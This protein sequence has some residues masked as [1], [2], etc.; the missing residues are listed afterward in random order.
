[1]DC[2]AVGHDAARV[3]P[4]CDV[5]TS[6]V[7]ERRA[8]SSRRHLVARP[9]LF[10]RAR[11]TLPPFSFRCLATHFPWVWSTRTRLPCTCACEA[12]P[13]ALAAHALPGKSGSPEERSALLPIHSLSRPSTPSQPPPLVGLGECL[14]SSDLL[15]M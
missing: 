11:H 10:Q 12:F 6:D 5:R 14:R 3:K 1:M 4:Q 2:D 13:P 9:R 7:G 15:I 8:L